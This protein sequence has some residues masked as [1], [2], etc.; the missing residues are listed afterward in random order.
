MNAISAPAEVL[1]RQRE[2]SD[3][4]VSAW[5]SANAGSGKTYV[6]AQRVIRLLLDGTDPAKILCLT[7]TKAA[8]ANMANRVFGE[9]SK[10]ASHDDAA[11]DEAI[12]QIGVKSV[13][14]ALRARARRLFAQALETPGG[15]KVQTIHAFCT[16][17][18]H[19]FPFEANVAARFEVLDERA[20]NELLDRTRLAVLLEAAASPQ[21]ETG[22]ALAAATAGVADSSFVQVIDEAVRQREK[23]SAWIAP[24]GGVDAAM[25][26][27]CG[28]LE[29]SPGDTIENIDEQ[30]VNGP[31]F[32]PADWAAVAK[33][34]AASSTRDQEQARRLKTASD[35]TG[36][37]RKLAYLSIFFTDKET[38]RAAVITATLA[39][40]HPAVAELLSREQGRLET[41]QERRRAVICRDNTSALLTIANQVIVRYRAEKERRGVLD[42][43]DLISLTLDLLSRVEAAWVHYKLDLGIDHVLVDEAQDTSPRQWEIIERLVSE[44]T[45][46][47]GAREG[48]NRSIFAVGDEKQSIFSFQGAAPDAFAK[49]WRSFKRAYEA[50]EQ[51][52]VPIEF[53]YSF[54]S[55]QVI[56]DAVDTV[57]KRPEAYSG[58]TAETAQIPTAHT[59]VRANAPGHVEIWPLE[60]PSA[61]PEIKP[62]DAPF[63]ATTEDNPRITLASK[64]AAAVKTWLARGDSIAEEGQRRRVE[65]RDILILVRQRGALFE[66][67]IRAL[68]NAGIA[69]AGADRLVLTEHIAV[70]DLMALADALLLPDDD[71]ALATVLKSPLFGLDDNDLFALAHARTGTLREALRASGDRRFIAA[72]EKLDAHERAALTE[73]PFVFYSR[74]LGAE[75]GRARILERLGTEAI[76]ALDEFLDLALE[77]ERREIPSLQGFVQWLR[78]ANAEI[79]R[80]M[81]MGRNEVRVMTVHGAKG[82][83][84]PIVI[85]ADTVTPPA[86][87]SQRQPKLLALP[88]G[89]AA[90]G[91]PDRLIWAARKQDDSSLMATARTAAATA[92]EHEYRR[93]LYVAMTRAADRLII[94]GARG[95][96]AIPENCWYKL[97]TEALAADAREV[98]ADHGDGDVLRWSKTADEE[99]APA[100]ALPPRSAISLPGW[101]GQPAAP[102]SNAKSI[103][104]SFDERA[105]GQDSLARKDRQRA[106]A[107]GTITH[108]LLQ[109]LPALAPERRV[110]AAQNYLARAASQFSPDERDTMLRQAQTVIDDPRFAALFAPGGRTEVSIAGNLVTDAGQKIVVNGQIDRLVVTESE[111]IIADY[112]TNRPAPRSPDAVPDSYRRQLAL[113]RNVLMKVYPGRTVRCLLV[114]TDVPDLM[115]LSPELLE[116]EI[117]AVTTA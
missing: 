64:I 26:D 89:D 63:D 110:A 57:F 117:N 36:E 105:S 45:A 96:K 107:R 8:A 12:K 10:W 73:T 93:L 4:S 44:F 102:A 34:C 7:F 101:L 78:S 40:Q 91:A 100:A 67:I 13:D 11:L 80:D 42:Y 66:A 60:E 38:P 74:V 22:R 54:R 37:A 108:R 41:L 28:A 15:L 1:A 112:K 85:L 3:P 83:E 39:K 114:W 50:A 81:E 95:E 65:P 16:R 58:L 98:A 51:P 68:K 27:L 47:K 43:E 75:R 5:V 59:A 52:L 90:P 49:M 71:L 69:V 2:A 116:R 94:C 97:V 30:M 17:L 106:M 20:Q 25:A 104:P 70:M 113:Y 9:L 53:K 77:Y 76:D 55:L 31:I 115:E 88:A 19:Q 29:I 79:K 48:R 82:L 62:W 103:S 24:A 87:P 33:L 46:G 84:A 18:L 32:P 86:G 109:S 111:V 56:L 21:S 99:A 14:A 72:S 23:I 92:A 35:A 61:K 6:L